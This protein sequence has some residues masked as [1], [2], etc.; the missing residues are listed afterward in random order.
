MNPFINQL[1]PT[2]SSR[3][4]VVETRL[5]QG[6]KKNG[7]FTS[8]K[9]QWL[10]PNSTEGYLVLGYRETGEPVMLD[11]SKPNS[12]SILVAGDR[13]SGKTGFLQSLARQTLLHD[14]GDTQ[15]GVI[16]PFPEEWKKEE[17]LP[18]CLGVWPIY[19]LAASS[20]ISQLIPWAEVLPKSRQVILLFFDGIEQLAA[21]GYQVREDLRWL[22]VQGPES[23]IWPIVTTNPA[24]FPRIESWLDFFHTRVLGKIASPYLAGLLAGEHGIELAELIPA[25]QLCL[26]Q[27]KQWIRFLPSDD[28]VRVDPLFG[29]CS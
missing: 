5:S 2:Q 20:F 1:D 24:K 22:L 6:I 13:G 29:G 12:G 9:L 17:A 15:F 14:P 18:G 19:H 25:R 28:L 21:S 23:H 16:T 11:L 27:M 4:I 10:P 7:L 26:K 8:S 3:E